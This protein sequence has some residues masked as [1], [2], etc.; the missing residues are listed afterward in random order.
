M[1]GL[2]SWR[3]FWIFWLG[4]LAIL[5]YLLVNGSQ[6]FTEAAPQGML[7]HQSAGTAER[8]NEIQNSWVAAGKLTWVK[9][10]MVADLFFIGLYS[11]GGIIGGR[12]IWQEARS[13]SRLRSKSS[14]YWS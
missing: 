9:Y 10:A 2:Y 5:G 4:G 13:P 11:L 6:L 12:L 14:A 7:D 8:I 1:S 3:N